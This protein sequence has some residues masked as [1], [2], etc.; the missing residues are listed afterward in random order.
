MT[1]RSRW[2]LDLSDFVGGDSFPAGALNATVHVEIVGGEFASARANLSGLNVQLVGPVVLQRIGF[3][4]AL[5]QS[6]FKNSKCVPHVGIREKSLAEIRNIL[7]ALGLSREYVNETVPDLRF[8]YGTPSSALCGEVGLRHRLP[9]GQA[10]QG[11]RRPRHRQLL[12]RPAGRVP[13]AGRHRAVRRARH[14]VSGGGVYSNSFMDLRTE[15]RLNMA[16]IVS[17]E[18]FIIVQVDP[19]NRK[20]NAEAGVEGASF[21]STSA[22]GCA[23]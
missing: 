17:L 19:P 10:R 2:R 7:V 9:V 4:L 1:S 21:P 12:G 16:D 18:G 22:P 13:A 8:D 14:G 11:R 15:F 3:S 20:F 6:D 5:A 23:G